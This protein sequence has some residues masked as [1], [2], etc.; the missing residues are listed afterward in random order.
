MNVPFASP[1]A[2]TDALRPLSEGESLWFIFSGDK[3]LTAE[4]G[5]NIPD[6]PCL[7]LKRNLYI[8]TLA[9]QHLFAA[10]AET[11][12]ATQIPSGWHWKSLRAL[13]GV[14]SDEY[15]AIAGRAMQLLGWDRVHKYCGSC[16]KETFIREVERCRECPS[17]GHLA[18]PKLAPAVMA[19]VRRDN[20]ILL[21]R[22]PHFPEKFYSVIAGYVD[23]GETLEQCI[24]R[25][26]LEEVGIKIKNIRY[27]GSQPW[28]FSYSLMIAFTCDWE[29]GEISIDPMELTDA[30][31]F[32]H[33]NLPQ[34]P[35]RLSISRMIIDTYLSTPLS[36]NGEHSPASL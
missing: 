32:D 35:P 31:W 18:Y 20:K 34:L 8:G 9:G 26:V 29:E 17:C 10:E 6:Q 15:Y 2:F 24:H 27:F 12:Q 22:G 5:Q 23:P 36:F 14:L 11:E 4:N 33:S 21:A 13:Y 19:L 25:E 28:P 1:P 30:N 7:N 3:L 16:G